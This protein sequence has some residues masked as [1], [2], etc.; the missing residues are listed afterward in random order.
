MTQFIPS[1]SVRPA[2]L[3]LVALIAVGAASCGGGGGDGGVGESD[4]TA[5]AAPQDPALVPSSAF[6]SVAGFIGYLNGLAQSDNAEPLGTGT[7]AA[8]ISDNDEPS[9]V[10]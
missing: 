3:I 10:S 2:R 1:G 6:A 9:N 8:P 5:G 4:M 7:G